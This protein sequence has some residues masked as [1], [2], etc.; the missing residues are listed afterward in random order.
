MGASL[1][2]AGRIMTRSLASIALILAAFT[3]A[4]PA[5]AQ[6]IY[7]CERDGKITFTDYPCERPM[8]REQGPGASKPDSAA[9]QVIV[10]GGYENPYGPW[11][12]QAQYQVTN[13]RLNPSG[14]HFVVPLIL[15]VNDDGKVEGASPENGCRMLGLAS[16]GLTPKI[17]NLDVTVSNCPAKDFN[18]RYRG[19]LILNTS[20]R[21]AR[22]ALN[23]QRIGVGRALIADIKA[24][25][26]R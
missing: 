8:T 26:R 9:T 21:S 12:G 3:I 23:A 22:V 17:L 13:T 11:R 25:M 10:G 2:L 15:Q 18:Q 5:F 20:D 16:P 6:T 1:R 14:T 19:T 24:I 4:T 7:R